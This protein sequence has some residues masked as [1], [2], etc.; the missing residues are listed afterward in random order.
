MG[1]NALYDFNVADGSG[2][3][4]AVGYNTGRGIVTGIN[5]TILGAN[6]TGLASALSNTVILADGSGNQRLYID[7]SGRAGIGITPTATLTLPAG[8]AAT[9]GAPL[10]LTA[11][12]NLT[13]PENGAIEFDGLHLYITIAGVRT[14]IV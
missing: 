2:N 10:K 9:S 14:T 5:N 6:V 4:T 12:V 11:G 1:V 3:N 8:V 7:S 13:T